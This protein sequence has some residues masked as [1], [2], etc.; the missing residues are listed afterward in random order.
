MRLCIYE[1]VQRVYE[2]NVRRWKWPRTPRRRFFVTLITFT[3]NFAEQS[4]CRKRNQFRTVCLAVVINRFFPPE[5]VCERA[6][7]VC[8]DVILLPLLR[9]HAHDRWRHLGLARVDGVQQVLLTVVGV[10]SLG[11][12][13]IKSFNFKKALLLWPAVTLVAVGVE[14]KGNVLQ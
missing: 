2:R 3:Q 1:Y 11:A 7:D 8:R 10:P 5:G 13:E 14:F 4:R 12:E 6:R 9:G